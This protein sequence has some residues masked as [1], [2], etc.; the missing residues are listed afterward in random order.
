MIDFK[1]GIPND[2]PKGYGGKIGFTKVDAD[3]GGDIT[4]LLDVLNQ[5]GEIE[6]NPMELATALDVHNT[7][8]WE[9]AGMST[10]YLVKL[11]ILIERQRQAAANPGA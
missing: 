4:G 10:P 11:G 3:Y 8:V 7:L 6:L 1:N 2:T 5:C 9:C